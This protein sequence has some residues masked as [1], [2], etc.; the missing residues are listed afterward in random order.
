MDVGYFMCAFVASEGLSVDGVVENVF[1]DV[2]YD[3]FC[4]VVVE[5]G[6]VLSKENVGEELFM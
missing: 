6:V 2:Y 3:V 1:V 4:E 5:F